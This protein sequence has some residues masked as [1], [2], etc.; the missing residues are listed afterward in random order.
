MKLFERIISIFEHTAK[1][2]LMNLLRGRSNEQLTEW[3]YSPQLLRQGINAWPWHDDQHIEEQ[4]HI[5]ALRGLSD[6]DLKDLGI[7]RGGIPHAVRHGR[8]G[9][10][11]ATQ[12]REPEAA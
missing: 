3:G 6:R 5:A 10:D 9:I 11:T 12:K 2:R 1:V 8:E 4:Q 7:S